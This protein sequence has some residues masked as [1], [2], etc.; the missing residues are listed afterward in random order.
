MDHLAKFA[1]LLEKAK[2]NRTLRQFA[3]D[4]G[5]S[6]TYLNNYINMKYDTPPGIEQLQKIATSCRNGVT[7]EDLLIACKYIPDKKFIP[8]N[9]DLIKGDLSYKELSVAIAKKIDMRL[10]STLTGE[11]IE[12]Y[13]K[14]LDT[15]TRSEVQLFAFFAEIDLD[16]FYREN[17]IEDLHKARTMYKSKQEFLKKNC[18]GCEIQ[19]LINE[20]NSTGVDFHEL[21]KVLTVKENANQLAYLIDLMKKNLPDE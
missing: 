3:E 8:Q 19:N 11:M 10:I 18:E 16:F 17:T 7:Y 15:P 1:K 2:G 13:A 9:I 4:T 6:R 21:L 14:G 12:E 5:V 20:L